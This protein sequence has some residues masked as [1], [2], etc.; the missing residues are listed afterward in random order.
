MKVIAR[1]SYSWT[2]DDDTTPNWVQTHISNLTSVLQNNADVIASLEAGFIGQWGEWASS[3]NF[4]A[5][6]ASLAPTDLANRRAV[7]DALL[8]A[9]PSSR[10][11]QLRRPLYKTQW[12]G[13]ALAS[14]EAFQNTEKA[15]I[16]HHNDC[17]VASFD[18]EGT[19]GSDIAG[20]KAYLGAENLYVPQGGETCAWDSNYSPWS[21]AQPQLSA[22]HWSSL[23]LDWSPDVLAS[24]WFNGTSNLDVLRR[25]LG[26]RFSLLSG[27]YSTSARSNGNLS[28]GFTVH[29][30]GYAAPYNPRD[31]KIVLRNS[32]GAIYSFALSGT[33]TDPRRWTPGADTTV[34]PVSVALTGVPAGTYELLLNLS[35]PA[36]NT[37]SMNPLYAIRLANT[38][39]IWE[40][41]TGY[42]KLGANITVTP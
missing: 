28:V 14:S 42:N 40:S 26:Y 36:L 13:A 23:N 17:F 6:P 21:V 7:V 4:G 27:S 2:S 33:N 18:D 35:D 1:F 31:L 25:S 9:L 10:M 37:T 38:N 32:S 20:E 15:R 22:Q 24:Q 16:G 12:F 11:I 3:T 8:N 29:N 19:Y 41:S 30:S 34:G 39:N 5:N